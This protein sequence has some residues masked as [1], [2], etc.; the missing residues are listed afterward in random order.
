MGRATTFPRNEAGKGRRRDATAR[1]ILKLTQMTRS[2]NVKCALNCCRV[3]RQ[4]GIRP[5]GTFLPL[6]DPRQWLLNRFWVVKLF[7]SLPLFSLKNPTDFS[8]LFFQK[9]KKLRVRANVRD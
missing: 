5:R 3:G 2:G 7:L 9:K 8:S 4:N 1:R 6:R